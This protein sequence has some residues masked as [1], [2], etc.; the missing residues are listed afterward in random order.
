MLSTTPIGNP[1]F[2]FAPDLGLARVDCKDVRHCWTKHSRSLTAE[3]TYQTCKAVVILIMKLYRSL[4]LITFSY[5]VTCSGY[6]YQS[7]HEIDWIPT[8][9]GNSDMVYLNAMWAS[10]SL[11]TQNPST[12]PLHSVSTSVVQIIT[13]IPSRIG[14]LWQ[15]VYITVGGHTIGFKLRHL[16]VFINNY[17]G[18]PTFR[19]NCSFLGP[20]KR[21]STEM[22]YLV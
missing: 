3:Q 10:Q 2:V 19:S 15:S 1:L 6:L 18:V 20:K 8:R 11:R 17:P 13:G 14:R 7:I 22:T 21:V 12:D 9:S 5:P 4:H 16:P